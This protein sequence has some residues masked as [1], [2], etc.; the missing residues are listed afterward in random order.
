MGNSLHREFI[1]QHERPLSSLHVFCGA[2]CSAILYKGEVSSREL[3][4]VKLRQEVLHTLPFTIHSL[5]AR[6]QTHTHAYTHTHTYIHHSRLADL[7]VVSLT[8]R[9]GKY[10][11][12]CSCQ[13][14]LALS[15]SK[16]LKGTGSPLWS[17]IERKRYGDIEGEADCRDGP[18]W[19]TAHL[20]VH[21]AIL[22]ARKWSCMMFKAC[23]APQ[24]FLTPM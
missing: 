2:L 10:Q 12:L 8:S 1:P 5:P 19:I 7:A 9:L 20:Y 22:Q 21:T 15:F 6:T 23:A 13:F 4:S 17:C 3:T 24:R 16:F 18:S 14:S 11:T